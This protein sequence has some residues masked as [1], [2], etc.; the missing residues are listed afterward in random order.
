MTYIIAAAHCFYLAS[1]NIHKKL[2]ENILKAKMAFFDTKPLGMILNR[3]S[4]DMDTVGKLLSIIN[5]QNQSF[6]YCYCV[7]MRS[8]LLIESTTSKVW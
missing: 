6:I 4:K 2:L 3:F 7:F 5:I 8:Y 1:G